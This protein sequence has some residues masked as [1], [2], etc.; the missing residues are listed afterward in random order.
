MTDLLKTKVNHRVL[1]IGTGSGYQAAILSRLVSD[2]FTIEIVED[3]YSEAKKR[4]KQ[5]GYTNIHVYRGDGFLGVSSR[6]PFDGII[7]T[8]AIGEVP[9]ALLEQLKVGGRIVIPIGEWGGIQQL[10]LVTKTGLNSYTKKEI[11]PVR[12]VPF[13]RDKGNIN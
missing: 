6:S 3:L 9:P 11:L 7:V 10:T 1:E 5:L 4:L 8:A 2:V 13:T 12:F